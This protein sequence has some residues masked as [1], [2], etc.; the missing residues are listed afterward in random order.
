MELTQRLWAMQQGGRTVFPLNSLVI[1]L[2][3]L[4][5]FVSN[6]QNVLRLT[7]M[8]IRNLSVIK[9]D[10]LWRSYLGSLNFE[11]PETVKNPFL[12]DYNLRSMNVRTSGL[13]ARS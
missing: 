13:I 12:S 10:I 11:C 2:S 7:C 3:S 1:S 5:A 8:I 9:D 4:K 6:A